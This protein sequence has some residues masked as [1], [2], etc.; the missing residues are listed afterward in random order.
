MASMGMDSKVDD[1]E[2]RLR[3]KVESLSG[4]ADEET[5][6]AK[7]DA[8]FRHFDSDK[9]GFISFDEYNAALVRLNFVGVQAAVAAL[10]D[11]YDADGSGVLSYGE[12]SAC[13]FNL[14]PNVAGNPETRSAVE[15]VRRVIAERGGLNG[16][17][18]LAR[19]MATMDDSG[20]RK[21]DRDEFKYGLRDYGLELP[22]KDF[23]KV[24]TAFDRN[25]DGVIDFDEFL[26]GV[27]GKLN[28]RRRDLILMAYDVLDKDGSGIVDRRDIEA[29]YD[30][31]QNPDVVSGK[32]TAD[33][34]LTEFMS[35]WEGATTTDGI[36]TREEFLDYYK[37]VSASVD[38]DDYFELMIRNAWHISG[39]EGWAE[40]TSCLRVLVVHTDSSEEVVEI[41]DDLGLRADDMPAIKAR[42]RRQGVKNI[43]AVKL[44]M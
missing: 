11:R 7:L 35:Q 31:S 8:V 4:F 21:L 41:T 2:A 5:Q 15:R 34:A 19:I 27:R 29:A 18:T 40:N 6:A 37:D 25:G 33:E 38:D 24:L 3:T 26:R 28:K 12:F 13:L 9:S 1:L 22:E 16:I 32:K 36:I 44:G 43:A 42:L 39:G 14:K 10:F 17:R 30:V 20:N 23:D